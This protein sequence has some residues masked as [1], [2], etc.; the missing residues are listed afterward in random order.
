MCRIHIGGGGKTY[1][2]VIGVQRVL[3]AEGSTW[4]VLDTYR[5]W[6]ILFFPCDW[7]AE[8]SCGGGSSWHVLDTYQLQTLIRNTGHYQLQHHSRELS[9]FAARA[10][11]SPAGLESQEENPPEG[12]R[13]KQQS[14]CEQGSEQFPLGS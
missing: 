3:V 7:W 2:P 6:C 8:G 5:W 13:P 14:S 4:H 12:N 9:I 1:F 11:C 10:P